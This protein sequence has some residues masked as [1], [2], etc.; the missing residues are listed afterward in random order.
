MERRGW[1]ARPE[2]EVAATG[3][4]E[5]GVSSPICDSRDP[6]SRPAASPGSPGGKGETVALGRR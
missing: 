5:E 4:P 3:Q 1:P 2:R 6:G